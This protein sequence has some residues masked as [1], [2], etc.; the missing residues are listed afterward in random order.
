MKLYKGYP[1][2]YNVTRNPLLLG[3]FQNSNKTLEDIQKS[4]EDYLE[5]MIADMPHHGDLLKSYLIVSQGVV[6]LRRENEDLRNKLFQIHQIM[7]R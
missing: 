7:S 4:L 1:Q 2:I 5:T 6:A 3:R